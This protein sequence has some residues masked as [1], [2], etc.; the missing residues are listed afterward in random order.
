MDG[1]RDRFGRD[2][3]TAASTVH[4]DRA[5]VKEDHRLPPVD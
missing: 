5:E 2:A 1:I 3:I 4:R